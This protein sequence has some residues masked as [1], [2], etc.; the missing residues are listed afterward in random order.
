M[1]I[2]SLPGN[3]KGYRLLV[4]QNI[5]LKM[6]LLTLFLLM[7]LSQ[8]WAEGYGQ[9]ISLNKENITV[10]SALKQIEAQSEYLFLYDKSEI[11]VTKNVTIKANK[12]TI[13][14]TLEM[15]FE[16][17]PV[18]YK[19]FGKNIVLRKQI[20]P[21]KTLDQVSDINPATEIILTGQVTDEKGERLLGVSVLVK[22]TVNGTITDLNGNFELS[23]PDNNI[24]LQFSYV[25][26]LTQEVAIDNRTN[27]IIKLIPDP[28]G[29]EEVV[30]VG[31]GTVR[32]SDV[33]GSVSVVKSNDFNPGA[34]VSVEQALTGRVA[35]VQIYQKSGEPGSA[36][37]VKIRGASSINGS[38]TP[39]YVIDGMPVNNL[40]PVSASG[41]QFPSNPNP[42]NPLNSLNPSDIESIEIL[43]DASATAIYGSRGSN[44]VVLITTKRGANGKLKISYNGYYGIQKVSKNLALLSGS[45]YKQVLNDIIDAGGGVPGER[46]V[47]DVTNVDWQKEISRTASMQSHDINFSGGK[48]NTKFYASLGYFAQEGVLLNSE[49]NRYTA[50]INI[51][52]KVAGKYAFGVSLNTS[53]IKDKFNSVGIGVNENGSSLYTAINY[54]PTYPI[55]DESGEYFR[56]PYMSTMDQP[57]LLINGQSAD[58][59]AFRTFG[60]IY[61]EYFFLPSLSLKVRVGGDVNISQRN[62]WVDPAT[63]LGKPFGGV[64]TINTGNANYY[65]S[66]AIMNYNHDFGQDHSLSGLIGFTYDHYG[67]NSF[68]GTGRGYALPDLSYN[69]IGSGDPSKNIIGS[70]RAS[71]KIVSYLGRINYSYQSKYLATFSI[72][73]DGS[74]RFGPNN[75]FAYFPSAALAWKL[76]EEDVLKNISYLDELKLRTSY[77][78][79]GNQNI[80][81]YLYFT[82]FS[83]GPAAI[84]GDN[85]NASISPSRIANPD[86]KWEGAKQI[87]FG[88]DFSFFKRR[89]SGS[90]DY[91]SRRTNDLLLDLPLPLSTGFAIK[92]QNVGDMK[93]SGI[94]ISLNSEIIRSNEFNWNASVNF[95]TLKNEVLSLGPLNQIFSGGAGFLNNVSIIKPG[96]SIGSYYGYKVLGVWQE[97]D[98]FSNA[99]VGVKPGDFK[100]LDVDNNKQINA[101]DRMILGKSLPDFIYGFNSTIAFKGFSFGV[102]FEGQQGSSIINNAAVDSYFPLSFRRNKLAEPYLNRWTPSNP[103]NEYPSFINP[104]SQGQ[105][106]VNS[107]TVENASYLRFQSARISYDIGLGSNKWINKMQVYVTGQ[108]LATF[109]KY[110]GVD[111]SVNATGNDVVK[112]DYST[113]PLTRSF[114]LGVNLQ[115]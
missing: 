65:M 87:D 64:A 18:S 77:G 70:G 60:N 17:L 103:T 5:I 27:W 95:S 41:D 101:D 62:T 42:R 53:Y 40:S 99:P 23:V 19:I 71:T 67:S 32:K 33:T 51:E 78:I 56:S 84:F 63:I 66:E 4:P 38:N 114:L 90:I 31:Y 35:G 104:T 24:T 13:A 3:G 93:N 88:V 98:D 44:G 91:Y 100:F 107:R 16:G 2:N 25:G 49:T 86:L 102:F 59:D 47:N 54:D 6:K 109:T 9:K 39:L 37:S 76:H 52:N 81:N 112:I 58:G 96:E 11:Q 89:I 110:S 74:S 61:G 92:T 57:V 12:K 34:N 14:E 20:L 55:Y 36:M 94:E 115:F 50:K 108:N 28:M 45:D 111:P 69:A 43:K 22:G 79:V 83:V 85:L 10:E 97:S 113:Y 30:V 48:D 73:S 105:Q 46:V 8:V 29:L 80:S 68:S 1:E 15:L 75:R 82:S 72:R 106:T 21:L 7:A 26:Y